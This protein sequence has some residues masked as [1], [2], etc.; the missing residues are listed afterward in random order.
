MGPRTVL[1]QWSY[2]DT[3]EMATLRLVDGSTVTATDHHRFW[4]SSSA[5]SEKPNS[6]PP[7]S[8]WSRPRDRCRSDTV[9]RG[10]S[11][12]TLVWELT[13]AVDHT[14]AV[15]AGDNA[16]AVHN[17]GASHRSVRQTHDRS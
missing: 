16:I 1:N 6:S 15:F 11:A 8:G 10:A 5:P 13:V 3:D 17:Q 14:F 9:A 2:L 4:S 7:A 12:P